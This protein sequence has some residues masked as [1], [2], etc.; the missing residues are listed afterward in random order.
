MDYGPEQWI[1]VSYIERYDGW[2]WN[3]RLLSMNSRKSF[4][5]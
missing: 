3:L 2:S 5:T 1:D 4:S